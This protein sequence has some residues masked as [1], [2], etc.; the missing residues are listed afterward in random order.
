M[1]ANRKLFKK[2]EKPLKWS[3]IWML[4]CGWLL[5][6]LVITL[7]ILYVTSSMLNRQ[8]ERTIVLSADK[9]IEICDLQLKGAITASKNAS[10][11]TSVKDGYNQYKEDG[12]KN[13]LHARIGGFLNQQYKYDVGFSCTMLYFMEEPESIY[14][15]YNTYQDNN[16]I[17]SGYN[18]VQ[19]FKEYAQQEVIEGSRELDT[20]IKLMVKKG[21]LYLVRN[22]MNSDFIPYAMLII[23]LEP[24]IVFGS[25]ESVWGEWDYEVYVDGEP[26]FMDGVSDGFEESRLTDLTKK[27]VYSNENG[28]AYA[29]KV[30]PWEKQQLG[31]LVKLD[32]ESIIDETAM[33]GYVFWVVVIFM[34]PLV[35]MVFY[36]FQTKVTKPAAILVNAAKEIALGN[37]GHQIEPGN[38][39]EEFAYLDRA[40]NTMSAELKYQFETIYKEELALRDANIKALQ[41]QINPHF[42]NNTL[43][44]INWEARMNGNDKVSGMIEALATML[45]ATMNR[46]QRRFVPLAE[47]L[48]YVDAY[49]YIIQSRFGERFSVYREIDE[50]LLQTEVPI[51]IIQPIVE[52]AVTHGVE[53]NRKGSV[54]IRIYQKEDKLY[55]EVLNEGILSQKDKEKIA[56]LLGS[57]DMNP[58]EKHV[59][60][61]IR[62]VNQRLKII[63][64]EECGLTIKNDEESRTVSRI[65][66]KLLHEG[67]NSQ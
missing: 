18:R 50:N 30:I 15:T 29:Y 51:L 49:L 41:S 46:R 21:H 19:F 24:Q 64:G 54:G 20:G 53:E 32:S 35:F 2:K 3:M 44:I 43:E 22:L 55:I 8:I 6:L 13:R 26:L 39:S 1:E 14:Y 11:N 56:V 58:D 38:N 59:S 34:I 5:P 62:N 67:N 12:K 9:A 37:Y 36:F 17:N 40:F 42:L 52:N 27:S 60:I 7:S 65:I 10:Y 61:G 48:S 31:I 28:N 23:E 66:V 45:S 16:T 4:L 33:V 57:E 63:Y 25:L 47:E